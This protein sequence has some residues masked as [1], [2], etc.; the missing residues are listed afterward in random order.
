MNMVYTLPILSS[1]A[2]RENLAG[3][4]Y[5]LFTCSANISRGFITLLLSSSYI[6]LCRSW[7]KVGLS[8][9]PT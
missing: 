9:L 1:R 3:M 7:I 4:I 2:T 8:Y 6:F 5:K